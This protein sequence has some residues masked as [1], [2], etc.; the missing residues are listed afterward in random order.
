MQTGSCQVSAQPKQKE[1]PQ[2]H[3]TSFASAC[4]TKRGCARDAR[5]GSSP[6]IVSATCVRMGARVDASRRF[7]S[8][9]L[10]M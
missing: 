1:C 5:I 9:E 3:V 2:S 6:S 7:I 10:A 4:A 8:R